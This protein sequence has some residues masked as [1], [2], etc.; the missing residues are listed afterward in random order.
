VR[1]S[2]VPPVTLSDFS[3]TRRVAPTM[4]TSPSRASTRT[5][6]DSDRPR[7]PYPS[8]WNLRTV[9][10]DPRHP[11]EHSKLRGREPGD[12]KRGKAGHG[13]WTLVLALSS[14]DRTGAPEATNEHHFLPIDE[15]FPSPSRPGDGDVLR[16]RR[17]PAA[18]GSG[19]RGAGGQGLAREF[20][21]LP[22][23][24]GSLELTCSHG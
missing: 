11:K 10:K 17:R 23:S 4:L 13:F 8:S 16:Q 7:V 3:D 6:A 5:D 1:V 21:I 19:A 15:P 20:L 18:L 22:C 2:F 14:L 12:A 24:S 9:A